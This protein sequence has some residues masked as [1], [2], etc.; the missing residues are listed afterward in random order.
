VNVGQTKE[1]ALSVRNSGAAPLT[2]RSITSSNS[3]VSV[4]VSAGTL[5]APGTFPLTLAPSGAHNF[6]VRFTPASAGPLNA[7][8]TIA[9]NAA[10]AASL[11]V[12]VTGAGIQPTGPRVLQVDDGSFERSY[13]VAGGID[14]FYLNRLTPV[15]YPATLKAVQ[16]FVPDDGPPP[17]AAATILSTAHSTGASEIGAVSLRATDW[18]ISASGRFI[19]IAV[20][21]LTITA[22]DFLVGFTIAGAGDV[23]HV[24]VDTSNDSERSYQSTNGVNYTPVGQVVGG[25]R[26]NFGI[27]AVVEITTP[28]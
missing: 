23:K 16:V 18:R 26:G 28:Q 25:V 3:A 1:L 7:T 9:S 8:L 27:R 22:G 17:G 14:G 4:P 11:A 5:T 21:A 2:V 13:S 19:E 15:A 24:A 20:P 6:T 10:N 12:T